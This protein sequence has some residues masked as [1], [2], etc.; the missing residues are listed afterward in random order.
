MRQAAASSIPLS[1]S[2]ASKRL[3][4]GLSVNPRMLPPQ[5]PTTLATASRQA[6]GEPVEIQSTCRRSDVESAVI[7]A[8]VLGRWLRTG[9][10]H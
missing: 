10:A 4:D 6:C 3:P 8:G 7:M 1:R 5:G 9:G 2:T